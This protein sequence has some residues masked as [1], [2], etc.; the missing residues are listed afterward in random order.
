MNTDTK[1]LR[2]KRVA[3]GCELTI[4]DFIFEQYPNRF[5]LLDA[6]DKKEFG[7]TGGPIKRKRATRSDKGVRRVKPVDTKK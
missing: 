7:G 1:M 4:C 5:E 2:V 3:D 6:E